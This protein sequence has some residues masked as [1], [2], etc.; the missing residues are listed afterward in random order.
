[1]ADCVNWVPRLTVGLM[2]KLDLQVCSWNGIHLYVGV[3]YPVSCFNSV[4]QL[5]QI[6]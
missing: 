1:M 4:S 6:H 5:Y 3:L 2:D